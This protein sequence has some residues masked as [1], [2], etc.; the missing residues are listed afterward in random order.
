MLQIRNQWEKKPP[1]IPG[2]R[3]LIT[4]GIIIVYG[5]W[6]GKL[7]YFVE[8]AWPGLITHEPSF[9][10]VFLNRECKTIRRIKMNRIG[11]KSLNFCGTDYQH[12]YKPGH[13]LEVLLRNN[14]HIW[15]HKWLQKIAFSE[16]TYLLTPNMLQG[17]TAFFLSF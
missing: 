17:N 15:C 10:F 3:S 9:V 5:R 16:R 8:K 7:F 6:V 1:H 2:L 4:R 12:L 13:F 11:G 14:H